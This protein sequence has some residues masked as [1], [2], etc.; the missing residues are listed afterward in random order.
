MTTQHTVVHR[1]SGGIDLGGTKIQ[2]IVLS[3]SGQVVGQARRPTPTSGG[4]EAVTQAMAET[5]QEAAQDAATTTRAL[6]SPV[7]SDGRA[8]PQSALADLT[9]IPGYT[10]RAVDAMLTNFHLPH[11][12]LL[13]LVSAFAGREL[14]LNAYRHAV[15][16][17]YRFYSYGD[18]MLIL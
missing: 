16:E 8:L 3:P 6:E 2:A 15:M 1:P 9:V 7:A 5:M 18:C 13:L 4:P 14:T 10:F 17:R 11:S 12:S